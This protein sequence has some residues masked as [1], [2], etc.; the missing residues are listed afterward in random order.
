M[1]KIIKMLFAV[2]I[3]VVGVVVIASCDEN[4]K[5]KTY[6]VTFVTNGGNKVDA[7]TV[8]DGKLAT[9]PADPTRDGYEFGGWFTDTALSVEYDFATPVVM[10]IKLYAGWSENEVEKITLVSSVSQNS[11]LLAFENNKAEKVNKRTEFIDRTG[12]YLVGTDNPFSVKPSV[13]FI[14]YDPKTKEVTPTVVTE[15]NYKIDVYHLNS[16]G[17]YTNAGENLVEAIDTKLCTVDFTPAAALEDNGEY[18]IVVTPE[19]LTDKQLESVTEYQT[20]IEIDVVPGF[21]VYNALELAYMENRKNT[22]DAATEAKDAWVAFKEEKGLDKNYNPANLILQKNI[23]ITVNDI[24]SCFIYHEEDLSKADSD[25]ERTLGSLKD[26]YFIY[27]HE[28]DADEDFNLYGN[29]FTLSTEELPVV[30]R[31]SGNITPEGEVISHATL[32]YFAGKDTNDATI[33]SIN[34]IGNAPRVENNVKAGGIIFNKTSDAK[35]LAYN[36]IAICWFIT[37]MPELT[38]SEYNIDSCK[39]Y[40][41]F[42]S[43]IYNWGGDKLKVVDSEMVGAGGPVIIQDHVHSSDPDG[44]KPGATVFDNCKIESHVVGT[45]GWFTVV[46]AA[47]LVPSIKALDALFTPFGRSFLTSN[48]DQSLTYLNLIAVVKSGS[49]QTITAEKIKGNVTINEHTFDY[50]ASANPYLAGLLDTTFGLGAPGFETNTANLNN[51]IGYGTNTGLFDVT[52]TQIVD[53]SNVIFTGDYLAMYYQGMMF[54]LGYGPS[55]Q[56]YTVE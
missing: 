6:T 44:G 54:I 4:S 12:K 38:S 16:E 35:F 52:Q 9:K 28:F 36:N 41:N 21:N 34:L 37:Y 13:S 2:I 14:S 43:F 5:V 40:N 39:C 33:Q 18:K 50:G 1:K 7:Q 19:G 56:I 53:P 30:T 42:N 46:K 45:E 20:V 23:S 22:V 29:Y 47:A 48:S 15:W 49:A 31:E 27:A 51:G 26:N 25:Y 24:P 55:G 17:V 3:A 32:V 10:N 8:E 11:N